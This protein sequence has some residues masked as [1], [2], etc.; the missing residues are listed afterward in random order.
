LVFVG[1]LAPVPIVSGLHR[2]GEKLW[3]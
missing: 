1:G 2:V 3:E